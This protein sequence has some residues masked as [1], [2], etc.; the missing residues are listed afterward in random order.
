MCTCVAFIVLS[1]GNTISLSLY[2][3][4][5]VV[6]MSNTYECLYQIRTVVAIR[7]LDAFQQVFVLI[8]LKWTSSEKNIISN[9]WTVSIWIS[10]QLI[11]F[12][13]AFCNKSLLQYIISFEYFIYA[14]Q[15][16]IEK[17]NAEIK[18]IQKL[19]EIYEFYSICLRTK[20]HHQWF[21]NLNEE[22]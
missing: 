1:E 12:F 14:V 7:L 22:I 8:C 17:C 10:W 5:C 4:R 18:S 20:D 11:M 15:E 13:F 16:V 3:V 19:H 6:C 21:E 2:A 9:I